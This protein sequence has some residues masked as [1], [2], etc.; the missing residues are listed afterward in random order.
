MTDALL[1]ALE[2][3]TAQLRR[4]ACGFWWLS[5]AAGQLYAHEIDEG[6]LLCLRCRSADGWRHAKRRLGGFA[7]IVRCA[8]KEG[9]LRI[10]GLPNPEQAKAIQDW[11]AL[12]A[13]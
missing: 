11:W 4:T 9:A 5:G 12:A 8:G 10:N 3:S 1:D 7:E 6:F 13:A 2:A